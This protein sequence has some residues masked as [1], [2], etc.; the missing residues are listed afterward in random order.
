LRAASSI[1]SRGAT[2][3]AR[4]IAY[5]TVKL[6]AAPPTRLFHLTAAGETTWHRFAT[7]ISRQAALTPVVNAIGAAEYPT[8]ARRP[9]NSVLDTTGLRQATGAIATW[10]EG[11][12]ACLGEL[13]AAGTPLAPG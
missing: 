7:E 2:T 1:F 3:W 9:A 12:T 4:D 13:L 5:A 10:D 8:A 11:L 6:P